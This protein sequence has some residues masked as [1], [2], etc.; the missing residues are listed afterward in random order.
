[1]KKMQIVTVLSTFVLSLC[2]ISCNAQKKSVQADSRQGAASPFGETFEAPCQMYDTPEEFA[3]T[4]IY[5]GSSNQK[6]DCQLNAMANARQQVY[7]KYHHAYKGLVSNYRGSY[8]NNRGNDIENK[9]NQAG[10]M[11]LDVVLNDIQASCVRFSG[12]RDDG[13]VECYVGI[14]VPKGKLAAET[15]RQVA[16]VLSAEEKRQI[17]FNEYKFRQ[18]MEERQKNFKSNY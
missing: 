11:A 3:A 4:G 10:D 6:G 9:L 17:D 15:A 12:V 14:R 5:L 8:G 2:L 18:E 16:N 1:M 7:E 13:M